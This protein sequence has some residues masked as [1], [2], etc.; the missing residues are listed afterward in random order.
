MEISNISGLFGSDPNWYRL[1]FQMS[2]DPWYV[3]DASGIILELNPAAERLLGLR[4]VEGGQSL[5]EMIA[6]PDR[7]GDFLRRIE[8]DGLVREARLGLETQGGAVIDAAVTATA[9]RVEGRLAGF[10]GSIRDVTL[11]T[12]TCALLADM[13]RFPADD[14]NPVMRI[15]EAG[16]VTYAN[17]ASA[18][19]LDAWSIQVGQTLPWEPLE[20]VRR[21]SADGRFRQFEMTIGGRAWLIDCARVAGQKSLNL[22]GLDITARREAEL[23]AG[24]QAADLARANAQLKLANERLNEEAKRLELIVRGIGDGV[25]VTD[26]KHRVTMLNRAAR[27]LL[28]LKGR[29][30]TGNLLTALLGDCAPEPERIKE[31]L[32]SCRP[33]R[34]EEFL[35]VLREPCARTLRIVASAWLDP[36]GRVA[37]RV[38][39]LRDVTREQ[40]IDRLKTDFVGSV[41]HELRTPLTSIKGFTKA[42]RQDGSMSEA[43][44]NQFLDIIDQE[45]LRLEALIEDLL[46][47]SR[48]ESGRFQLERHPV[49]VGG[50]IEATC[51]T[52]EPTIEGSALNLKLDIA[53][54]LPAPIGDR[55]ALHRVLIN[56]IGN[57]VKFT[58]AGGSISVGA[59][60]EGGG[61]LTITVAD[62]GIGIPQTDLP[63]IF[64]RFYRVHRPGTEIAGTGLGL[65]IV[66]EIVQRH[67]GTVGIESELGQGTKVTV[68]LPVQRPV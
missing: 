65:A 31:A 4:G 28:E 33:D 56:I 15:N 52:L 41:S 27:E 38:L 26:L 55:T 49:D 18:P 13:A 44:R 24:R 48:L 34:A 63:H 23:D 20:G 35:L 5:P 54:P 17:V 30:G 62:T 46:E 39:I 37:G 58:P 19:L 29:A 64:E 8:Q 66:H 53:S 25:I 2:A 6:E 59:A 42:L 36:S 51:E 7:R 50:L 60:A 68:K 67:G 16:V 32:E 47:I 21:C 1:A 43:M 45:T 3:A 9:V 57:A 10:F 40:E 12:R 22:Y 11:E 14:P 61:H